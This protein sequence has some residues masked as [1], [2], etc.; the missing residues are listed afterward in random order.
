MQ[1]IYRLGR[2]SFIVQGAIKWGWKSRLIFLKKGEFYS[3][4]FYDYVDQVLLYLK[5]AL[6]EFKE[7]I[8]LMEDG[9]RVYLGYV[10]GVCKLINIPTFFIQ[11]PALSPDLNGIEKVWRW[12][13][14][15]I[16]EMEPFPIIIKEFKAVV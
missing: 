3:I 15:K 4:D 5:H 2:T 9:V 14:N 1:S 6:A 16:L 7:D 13:K 10:K 11:W 8:I 12:M